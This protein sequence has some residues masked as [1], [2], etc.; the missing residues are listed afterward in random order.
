MGCS[1]SKSTAIEA[2]AAPQSGVG[3]QDPV[4]QTAAA[5]TVTTPIATEVSRAPK[6]KSDAPAT[7][8]TK[9][10]AAFVEDAIKLALGESVEEDLAVDI[11][12]SAVAVALE[13]TYTLRLGFREVPITEL[14]W[15][16]ARTTP[17]R[18]FLSEALSLLSDPQLYGT[19][20]SSSAHD[21]RLC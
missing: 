3:K 20:H 5:V 6:D 19:R 16:H 12:A 4:P 21:V 1:A 7:L 18:L 17:K 14:M 11:I 15:P 13:P 8:T 9:D 10:A 2:P